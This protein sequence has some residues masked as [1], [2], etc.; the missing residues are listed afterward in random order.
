MDIE[1]AGDAEDG[2]GARASF[3]PLDEADVIAIE[4]RELG[5]FL[6]AEPFGFA[7]AADLVA[8]RQKVSLF[9]LHAAMLRRCAKRSTYRW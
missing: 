5:Q 2:D 8:H 7:V 1:R 3:G 4:T 6:L 9:I